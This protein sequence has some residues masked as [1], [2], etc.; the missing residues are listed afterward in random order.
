MID[1]IDEKIKEMFEQ[2]KSDAEISLAVGRGADTIYIRRRV[3]GLKRKTG[4]KIANE[5]RNKSIELR[6]SGL[7]LEQI[8]TELGIHR[9]TVQRYMRGS[10]IQGMHLIRKEWKRVHFNHPYLKHSSIN[11]S[12]GSYAFR[13]LYGE[14]YQNKEW[15]FKVI[16]EKPNKIILEIREKPKGMTEILDMPIRDAFRIAEGLK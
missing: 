2:G 7:T 1:I 4:K 16:C 5:I 3:L 12:I 6:K 15:Q 8:A 11:F 9:N 14:D 10:G 13:E